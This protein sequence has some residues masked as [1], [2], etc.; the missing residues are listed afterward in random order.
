MLVDADVVAEAFDLGNGL[1]G[2][3][4]WEPWMNTTSLRIKATNL[5][6]GSTET[7]TE[8]VSGSGFNQGSLIFDTDTVSVS[9]VFNVDPGL[10]KV[11]VLDKDT[12]NNSPGT[13]EFSYFRYPEADDES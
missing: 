8:Q 12:V 9:T 4:C 7:I 13:M 1:A 6:T 2:V 3:S 5:L 10:V 11:E